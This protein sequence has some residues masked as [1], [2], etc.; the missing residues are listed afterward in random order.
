MISRM[1]SLDLYG[2]LLVGAG[3]LVMAL[4]LLRAIGDSAIAVASV[5]VIERRADEQRRRADNAAAEAAGK[6]AMLEPL[7]LNPDGT[8]EEPILGVVEP[9]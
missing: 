2:W 7:A 8:I 3:G 1:Q 9:R 6:A 4:V 5:T